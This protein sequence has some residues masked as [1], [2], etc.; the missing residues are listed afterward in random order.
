MAYTID[1]T[2]DIVINGFERGIG[3][4]PH[5]GAQPLIGQYGVGGLGNMINMNLVSVPGEASVNFSTSA[6]MDATA[7]G[8]IV[9]ANA[10][11]DTILISGTNLQQLQAVTFAGGSLPGGIVAG[12]V[13]WA[14][15]TGSG[16]Y[17]LFTDYAGV[18]VLNITSTGTG[19]YSTPVMGQP[20]YF[21]HFVTPWVDTYFMVD[22]L[23]QVWSLFITPITGNWRYTGN[24]ITG[25]NG[26]AHGNGLVSYVPSDA[27]TTTIGYLFVFRDFQIDYA[28]VTSNTTLTWTYGWTP[29]DGTSGH[30]NYLKS[31]TTGTNANLVHEAMVAPDNKVYYCDTNWIGRWY[32]ASPTVGFLPATASTYVFDQT[33]VLPFTDSA[34][35]LAPLG[36]TLLIGGRQNVVYPWDTFSQLPAYPILIPEYNVTKMITVNTNTFIFVGNRGRIYYTN[37]TNAQLFKKVPDF[38]SQTIEPYFTWGGVAS[39][40][41]QLYF[42]FS[43]T[44][45]SGVANTNYGGVWAIDLDTKAL[46]QT[47]TLSYQT[48]TYNGFASALIPN[49]STNPSGTGLYIGWDSGSSNYGVD[50][51]VSAPYSGS[52]AVAVGIIDSDLVPIGTFLLPSTNGQVEFKLTVPMVTGESIQLFY[53]QKFSDSFT[54]INQG[55][56]G[57]GLFN[58][59]TANTYSG[60]C[61]S[62]DFENSQW[63]Q[64]RAVMKST[65][66]SP[67]YTRL[68]ELRLRAAK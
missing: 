4:S 15:P 66:S 35:C 13:Y 25:A 29:S 62:V 21:N 24:S 60:V 49:F 64:I 33:S 39:V 61:Q 14:F 51:T 42:S 26:T 54:A 67:S 9:S 1:P 3:D 6:Q 40:K 8:T 44:T 50:T 56:V 19:T 28:T 36:N 57:N 16:N 45:N 32:Q 41:N 30:N 7:T 27:G 38:I 22:N 55:A 20:K 59:S 34:Q 12:T 68:F 31:A 10:G 5:P 53:R 2:G 58:G 11:A 37:G 47:N 43:V 18:T 17:Q 63:V 48:S 46:R 23:G 65:A 52:T